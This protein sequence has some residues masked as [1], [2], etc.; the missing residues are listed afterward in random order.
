MFLN[1]Q[2]INSGQVLRDEIALIDRID[3]VRLV[4]LRGQELINVSLFAERSGTNGMNFTDQLQ[5]SAPVR[6]VILA[7]TGA[8]HVVADG[9]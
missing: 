5:A 8:S 4:V 2:T 7:L 1:D 6:T 3:E 9:F